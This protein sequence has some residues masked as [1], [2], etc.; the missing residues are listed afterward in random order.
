MKP[1]KNLPS[2]EA[3]I[4][5]LGKLPGIGPKSATN[6]AYHLVSQSPERLRRLA[7]RISILPERVRDC[8]ICGNLTEVDP[9]SYCTD[10]ARDGSQLCVVESAVDLLSIERSGAYTGR[11]HVL[12]GVL[13]PLDGVGPAQLRIRELLERLRSGEVREII[14]ATN[15]SVEGEATANYLNQTVASLD[16]KISL[17]RF[18]RGLPVGGDLAY[19]DEETLAVAI[20]SRKM[21]EG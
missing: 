18:A 12:G 17:S 9:C 14:L 5:E 2:L 10:T 1:L 19:A 8:S 16:L 20:R 3:L 15:P 4:E 6:L 13:S 21:L 11:Y 7:E